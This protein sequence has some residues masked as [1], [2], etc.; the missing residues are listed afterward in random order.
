MPAFPFDNRATRAARAVAA[1]A[2]TLVGASRLPNDRRGF[3]E[4]A[5]RQVQTPKRRDDLV[6]PENPASELAPADF[7]DN[8]R[9]RE[10]R[11]LVARQGGEKKIVS[12]LV[13]EQRRYAM[14]RARKE[15][16]WA[17][18]RAFYEDRQFYTYDG[19]ETRL[20]SFLTQ[21]DQDH[22]FTVNL[23]EFLTRKVVALATQSQPDATAAPQ[24]DT[25]K[26]RLAAEEHASVNA[27]MDRQVGRA[28]QL[29]A[30]ATWALTTTTAYIK[31]T[32]DSDALAMVPEY[33][34]R[35]QVDGAKLL[36]VG[37]LRE[38]IAPGFEVFNDPIARTEDE[39]RA[40]HHVKLLPLSDIQARYGARGRMVQP[41][42]VGGALNGYVDAYIGGAGWGNAGGV[43][44][45]G[46]GAGG[47]GAPGPA[48]MDMGSISGAGGMEKAA[49]VI[50]RWELPTP[51][52]P[53]GRLITIANNVLLEYKEELPI[54][55]FKNGKYRLP[56]V[57]LGYKD[58]AGTSYA[59]NIVSPTIGLQVAFNK[60]YSTI[61]RQ[62]ANQKDYVFVDDRGEANPD[63]FKYGK[64]GWL[65]AIPLNM[66]QGAAPPVPSRGPGIDTARFA[67]LDS[68]YARIQDMFGVHDVSQ[69]KPQGGAT[70][71]ISINLLQESDQSQLSLFVAR[72]EQAMVS[73]K[74]IEGLYY[75]RYAVVDRLMG[76]DETGNP[77]ESGD[78][79]SQRQQGA[80]GLPQGFGAAPSPV[81]PLGDDDGSDAGMGMEPGL[82]GIGP[83]NGA[84]QGAGS[85]QAAMQSPPS[86]PP[87]T[88]ESVSRLR[89]VS[90]KNLMAGGQTC[91]IVTPGSG[92]PKSQAGKQQMS[93]ELYDRGVYGPP[94]TPTSA[95]MLV[96]LL[97]LTDSSSMLAHI[98]QW[99]EDE[100]EAQ[101]ALMQ[102]QQQQMALAAA[103]QAQKNSQ[104]ATDPLQLE[105]VKQQ[106]ETE[107]AMMGH[108][109]SAQQT[110]VQ[111]QVQL[112]QGRQQAA[113]DTRK[114]ILQH[115]LDAQMTRLN[116]G[117]E[118][119]KA[120]L[121]PK[122]PASSNGSG[123]KK[124]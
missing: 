11:E 56:F 111:A 10:M 102:M 7:A 3:V 1:R 62:A 79:P 83:D 6:D 90:F 33:D 57:P 93:F 69:G 68:Y 15:L 120:R 67:L 65:E 60:E 109:A 30:W 9:E 101:A 53:K 100:A 116:A 66:S 71:G 89:A 95:K 55:Y 113:L 32:W 12:W 80:Q 124:K 39:V 106:G 16:D 118:V 54:L 121:M 112:L 8:E 84:M 4:E 85:Q 51:D 40:R 52:F 73:V 122:P 77:A 105:Q 104:G 35:G 72:I 19:N 13:G 2:M 48:G 70:S 18:S 49:Y 78:N 98:D 25:P 5:N 63:I 42:P 24:L 34:A 86:P 21:D 61:Q 41:E 37:E 82:A 115:T 47:F 36:P 96:K 74:E 117:T 107:R 38:E 87:A 44:S 29:K 91:V 43:G 123:S 28:E 103:E 23:I 110:A 108:Q 88:T 45:S 58:M 20:V 94:G 97:Q 27:H 114:M 26:S 14:R 81:S 50:E 31:I 46:G 92:M 99:Q 76:V 22:Y 119:Q 59:G 64:P 17:L 75:A